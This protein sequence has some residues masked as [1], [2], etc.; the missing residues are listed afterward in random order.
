MNILLK[1]PEK[2][3]LKLYLIWYFSLALT[4][5]IMIGLLLDW[6]LAAFLLI[7]LSLGIPYARTSNRMIY[8]IELDDKNKTMT[9][10]YY[11]IYKNKKKT[12]AFKDLK[13]EL[14]S[15]TE[16]VSKKIKY[17]LIFLKGN[18][19]I[20]FISNHDRGMLTW[21]D[22]DIQFL[23]RYYYAEIRKNLS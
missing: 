17:D 15:T 11:V 6:R 5:T 10:Y 2:S 22:Q 1:C 20:G 7:P 8:Q 23:M 18:W 21:S 9:L 4:I 19:V 16:L 12:I 3:R 13:F 14:K